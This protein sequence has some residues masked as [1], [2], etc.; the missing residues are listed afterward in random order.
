MKCLVMVRASTEAQQIEDQHREMVNFCISEGYKE[1]DLIF[2]EDKGASAIKLNDSYQSMID[3][4]KEELSKNP[5]IGCF[6]VWE[7]SRAFR[8]EM[9]FQEVKQILLQ[10]KVQFIVYKPYLKLLNPDGTVNSGMEVA[11]SLLAVLAK[12][13]MEL[14]QERFHRAKSSMLSK[15]MY[16]GGNTVKFGYTVDKDGYFQPD[17]ETAPIVRTIYNL[18][19]TGKYS[20]KTLYKELVERGYNIKL[21]VINHT[22]NDDC[23]VDGP[24]PQMI[25]RKLWDKC[26]DMRKKHFLGL[27]KGKKFAFGAGILK[28]PECG[29]PLMV[30]G[31]HY[32]CW[33]HS[34]NSVGPYCPY[35]LCI[36][37][38]GMD[39]LLWWV[40]KQEEVKYQ[41][42]LDKDKEK[43]YQEKIDVLNQKIL[44]LQEKVDVFEYKKSKIVDTYLEDL[45]TKQE[46]DKKLNKLKQENQ[47]YQDTI[48]S[49]KEQIK[50]LKS[51]LENR[52]NGVDLEYLSSLYTGVIKHTDLKVMSEIVHRHLTSVTCIPIYYGKDRDRRAKTHNAQLVTITT[53]SGKVQKYAY[54]QKGY[55]G[56]NYFF[57]KENGSEIPILHIHKIKREPNRHK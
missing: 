34:S 52:D 10:R 2:V 56:H 6:A 15:G 41:M 11:V 20:Q 45:I 12:Q 26:R 23:Y 8:N 57:Y 24:Y 30:N 3:Q 28:C 40:A 22:L 54:V 48:L 42:Q 37:I 21:S 36:Q 44:A 47:S 33:H 46:R 31:T 1:K 14:K 49:Y 5:Q 51:I 7:L 4:V 29:R 39:G 17:P 25:S 13:E 53:V 35:P 16:I 38:A 27:P 55:K 19:S 43:E 50:S 9:V 18:Y 32:V